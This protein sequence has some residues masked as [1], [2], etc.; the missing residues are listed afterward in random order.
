MMPLDPPDPLVLDTKPLGRRAGAMRT[1]ERTV[2]APEGWTVSS[3][4]VEPGSPIALQL[5]MESVVDG[6]RVSGR[7]RVGTVA[8]C[9]RCLDPIRGELETGNSEKPVKAPR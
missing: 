4:S 6:V 9:S 7:A 2:P 1:I 8:E 3:S 5:R